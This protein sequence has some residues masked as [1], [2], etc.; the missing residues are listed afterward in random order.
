VE[1][2]LKTLND[3]HIVVINL[4]AEDIFAYVSDFGNLVVWSGST[5][6]ARKISPGE[7]Q[8]GAMVCS[9]HRFLGRWMDMTFEIVEYEPSRCL[10]IKSLSGVTPCLF[11]YQFEPL[12][13]SATRV[14]LEVVIQLTGGMLGLTVSG[15]EQV[16]RRQFAHDLLTLKDVLEDTIA[17]TNRSVV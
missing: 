2:L 13:D 6:A 17:V 4:S 8:V 12:E 9:T 5:I 11:S 10:T 1:V 7:M 3:R 16:V 15:V 14:C